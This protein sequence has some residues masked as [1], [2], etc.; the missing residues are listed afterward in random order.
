MLKPALAR[1]ELKCVGA[2]TI[3]EYRKYIEKDAA[4][5]RR[6][7][8][9][10]VEEPDVE[11]TISI[12]RGLKEKYEVHHGVRIK[13]SALVA[14]ATAIDVNRAV[15]NVGSG[16]E[17]S[18]NELAAC[19]ARVTGRRANVLHNQTQS[20][21]VSRLVADV[22]LARQLLGWIPRTE[23][24]EGLRQT[25]ERDPRFQPRSV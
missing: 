24:E 10:M 12:L 3:K 9:V 2:T 8:P 16:Q 1:G 11:D 6:F 15:I 5:E 18:I 7:Q 19:V 13:D 23:L 17:V 4:F 14:A 20:G 25:L 22:S 21:G